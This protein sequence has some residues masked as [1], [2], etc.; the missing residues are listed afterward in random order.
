[1][2]RKAKAS[3]KLKL[4]EVEAKL[5]EGKGLTFEDTCVRFF[6]PGATPHAQKTLNIYRTHMGSWH[7]TIVRSLIPRSL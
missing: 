4:R 2:P 3:L 5:K 1:M 6:T 7:A